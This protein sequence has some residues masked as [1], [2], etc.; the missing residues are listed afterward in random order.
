M[1]CFDNDVNLVLMNFLWNISSDTEYDFVIL[2]TRKMYSFFR[3]YRIS[4]QKQSKP[5]ILAS[6]AIPFMKNDF[7]DKRV[8]IVDDIRIHGRT[9]A[10]IS[11]ELSSGQYAPKCIDYN[12]FII[13]DSSLSELDTSVESDHHF[14]Y[15]L[16]LPRNMW[17]KISRQI[18]ERIR[19]T[20]TPLRSSVCF[21]HISTCIPREQF[22]QK[23][24]LVE[25]KNYDPEYDVVKSY[26]WYPEST[27]RPDLYSGFLEHFCIRIDFSNN[28][29]DKVLVVPHVI[30]KPLC[31]ADSGK[32]FEKITNN[33]VP[34]EAMCRF[35]E[36]AV[37]QWGMQ[38]AM[39]EL[40]SK[41]GLSEDSFK[42]DDSDL[43]YN[44]SRDLI[45][46]A[47]CSEFSRCFEEILRTSV[48]PYRLSENGGN[49]MEMI[50][51]RTRPKCTL[52]YL[53][54]LCESGFADEL[55]YSL[56]ETRRID[57]S[58]VQFLLNIINVDLKDIIYALTESITTYRY[59]STSGWTTMRI[60]PGESAF[61]YLLFE[62]KETVITVQDIISSCRLLDGEINK[63]AVINKFNKYWT[64]TSQKITEDI[65]VILESLEEFMKERSNKSKLK[66]N[67]DTC[68]RYIQYM[69]DIGVFRKYSS[70]SLSSSK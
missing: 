42:L 50:G 68:Y 70:H 31:E 23:L 48:R 34:Q 18:V 39:H 1:E 20:L 10:K 22:V 5:T 30:L 9:V 52:G 19:Q 58:R 29:P 40:Q 59:T 36:Y 53:R 60:L 6:D 24:N 64:A 47:R 51:S 3:S 28:Q 63:S 26:I 35:F 8:L 7:K 14:T 38:V 27:E 66:R 12:V 32:L 17:R 13:D 4:K 56:K 67:E 46:Y 25:L 55:L 15:Y 69:T 57:G 45:E 33:K 62:N 41:L 43:D 2:M 44:Y 16:S 61:S 65:F 21:A 11:E 49:I 37:S 54:Y